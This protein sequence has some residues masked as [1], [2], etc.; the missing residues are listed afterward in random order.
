MHDAEAGAAGAGGFDGNAALLRV[1]VGDEDEV[2][3]HALYR[4]IAERAL[5][6]GLAGATVLPGPLGYG[7]SRS[8]RSEYTIDAGVR[9]PIVVE[10]VDSMAKIE[11]FLPVLDGLVGSGLVTVETVRARYYPGGARDQD[12]AD[13]HAS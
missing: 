6:A 4:V 1:F 8:L 13:G 2:E 10:I 5:E 11:A 7:Q 9:V 12:D 3:G